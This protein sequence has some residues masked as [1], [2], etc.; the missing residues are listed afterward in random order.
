[1][2]TETLN[3]NTDAE[4]MADKIINN[5][6][7]HSFERLA[8]G[9]VILFVSGKKCGEYDGTDAAFTEL[10]PDDVNDAL[11]KIVD[12]EF[13]KRQFETES[14][15]DKWNEAREARFAELVQLVGKL[16]PA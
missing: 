2:K 7:F 3:T 10:T 12:E 1:M 5:S 4:Q 16:L 14:D 9:T 6:P 8:D 11:G 15:E 13:P